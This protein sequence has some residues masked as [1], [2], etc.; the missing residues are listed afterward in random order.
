MKRR[1]ALLIGGGLFVAA[2]VISGRS[3]LKIKV[4]GSG[5]YLTPQV[6]AIATE[7]GAKEW[8]FCSRLDAPL[9]QAKVM[10]LP[11][12]NF[13]SVRHDGAYLIIDV[14][15]ETEH[16]SKVDYKPLKADVSGTVHRI[17][18]VCGTA[19]RAVGDTVSAGD[20]LIGAYEADEE[21]ERTDCLAVGFAEI[22]ASAQLSLYY[23]EESEENTQSALKAASLY[24]EKVVSRSYTVSPCEEGV[25]YEVSFTYLKTVAINME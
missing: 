22:C 17:V 20:I 9:L 24:S 15:T 5:S 16:T 11:Y 18:A 10:A 2:A 12:V 1:F 23:N 6:V 21:G 8:S 3:V 19:E 4:V 25:K 7:C 13:C 14:R